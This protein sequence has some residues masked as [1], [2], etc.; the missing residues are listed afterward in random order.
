MPFTPEDCEYSS[1][2]YTESLGVHYRCNYIKDINDD[3]RRLCDLDSGDVF[4][5]PECSVFH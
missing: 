3:K 5:L 1:E 4:K 2:F